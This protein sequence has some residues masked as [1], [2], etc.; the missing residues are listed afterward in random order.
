M[1]NEEGW[2]QHLSSTIPL[3]LSRVR[4]LLA[5]LAPTIASNANANASSG[6]SSSMGAPK[7]RPAGPPSS[8]RAASS[9]L[10]I[11]KVGRRLGMLPIR[12]T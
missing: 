2:E 5:P 11:A 6:S 1:P 10:P 4:L 9:M 8:I 12:A 3:A 7:G